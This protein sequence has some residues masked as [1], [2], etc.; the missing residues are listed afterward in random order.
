MSKETQV[1][2]ACVSR[3]V[4]M[5]EKEMRETDKRDRQTGA[6]VNSCS[7]CHDSRHALLKDRR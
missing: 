3:G 5:S 4:C 2:G 7:S 6:A 1:G